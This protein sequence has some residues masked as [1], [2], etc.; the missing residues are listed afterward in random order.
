V[1]IH[2]LWHFNPE[3]VMAID[4]SILPQSAY[5]AVY[6]LGGEYAIRLLHYGLF[7]V[8][9]LLIEGYVRKTFNRAVAF[10]TTLT[11]ILTPFLLMEFGVVYTD[12]FYF[13]SAILFFIYFINII[14][15]L[16]LETLNYYFIL[17]AFI[18]LTKLQGMFIIIPCSIILLVSIISQRE[19][20]AIAYALSGLFLFTLILTPIL[21]HNY[22]V[23]GNP[24]FPWF[25][26]VFQSP[27]FVS[28]M[29]FQG[30]W[31]KPL[32]WDSLYDITF[33]GA[34]YI[35]NIN[36]SLGVSYF[37]FLP[38]IFFIFKKQD[39]DSKKSRFIILF[40][41]VTS[42]LLCSFITGTNMRYW[43]AIL[44]FG[45]ILVGL[46]IEAISER[47]ER[48][49]VL[50]RSFQA[51]LVLVFL[52]N[53]ICQLGV[54][55]T[56]SP[57]PILTAFTKNYGK[58]H[59]TQSKLQRQVFEFASLKYGS[60]A[61][62]LLIDTVALYFANCDATTNHWY[63][64]NESM[65]LFKASSFFTV[66]QKAIDTLATDKRLDSFSKAL[67]ALKNKVFTDERQFLDAIEIQSRTQLTPELKQRILNET[68]LATTPTLT[69]AALF[70][71]IFNVYRFD[72][73]IMPETT[74]DEL[75]NA[76][77]FRALLTKQYA[78]QELG[79]YSPKVN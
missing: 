20:C 63:H 72:Y 17:C 31:Q 76:K 67:N 33:Y 22:L 39:N 43:I 61:K 57:Y 6:V 36:Y 15:N 34:S 26:K 9:F 37:I 44:P 24:I 35:Q 54:I 12:S 46:I 41:F 53:F 1:S 50:T 52:T 27:W 40:T 47:F 14:H 18:M 19:F 5:T 45:A 71:I 74:T 59:L 38:F 77:E 58:S 11:L 21:A 79:L 4:P 51:I 56:A 32:S 7:F 73:I 28:D 13:F 29:N 75:L 25:N 68:R 65:R 3:F 78:N 69:P 8:G 42:F 64:S 49:A 55:N 66:N 62:C 23:S 10:Y 30:E 70:H 16:T 48:Q 2:G 60:K